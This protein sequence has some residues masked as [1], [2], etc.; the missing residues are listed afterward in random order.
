MNFDLA[1]ILENK[2]Q[3]RRA[4]AAL[5]IEEDNSP[6]IITPR[7]ALPKR[8]DEVATKDRLAVLR[9]GKLPASVSAMSLMLTHCIR[10]RS[11]AMS[12]SAIQ[13]PATPLSSCARLAG[14]LTA[15]RLRASRSTPTNPVQ[16]MPRRFAASRPRRSSES[17]TTIMI[18]QRG[19]AARVA[20]SSRASATS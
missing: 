15:P 18:A 16:V 4:L 17:A 13:N 11:R 14:S 10:Y 12:S 20:A 5:P 1:R 7:T 19:R 8:L 9:E 3:H 2:R 6:D